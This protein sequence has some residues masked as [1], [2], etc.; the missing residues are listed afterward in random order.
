MV[1]LGLGSSSDR[2]LDSF[3]F[4]GFM[5][6]DDNIHLVV[7]HFNKAT[8]V[9]PS[10]KVS[11]I[12]LIGLLTEAIGMMQSASCQEIDPEDCKLPVFIAIDD[13]AIPE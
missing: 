5:M 6:S 10:R 11:R 4:G 8:W 9:K 2:D 1:F 13:S 3:I 12:Y 7:S